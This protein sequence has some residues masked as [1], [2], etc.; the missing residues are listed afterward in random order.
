MTPKPA[1]TYRPPRDRRELIH[2]VGCVLAV[3]VFTAIMLWVL[4][5]DDDTPPVTPPF[6]VPSDPSGT[7]PIDPTATTI[8]GTPTDTTPT[9]APG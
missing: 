5:P 7:V 2:A 9:S 1:R 3:I 6:T 8:P 4:K